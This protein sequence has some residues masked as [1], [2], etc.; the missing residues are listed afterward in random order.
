MKKVIFKCKECGI[1]EVDIFHPTL[2]KKCNMCRQ[3]MKTIKGQMQT[4]LI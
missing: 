1:E 2:K 4:T 3:P